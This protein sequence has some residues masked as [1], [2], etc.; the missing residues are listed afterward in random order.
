LEINN[1]SFPHPASR[2]YSPISQSQNPHRSYGYACGFAQSK[3]MNLTY[4]RARNSM[5]YLFPMPYEAIYSFQP[6]RSLGNSP[7]GIFQRVL[8][9]SIGEADMAGAAEGRAGYQRHAGF[10]QQPFADGYIIGE[11]GSA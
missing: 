3:Q 7:H 4:I 1:S 6:F 5:A 8:R 11:F 10:V 9:D 2:L